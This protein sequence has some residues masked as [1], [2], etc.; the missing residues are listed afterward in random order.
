[1]R[2]NNGEH[3]LTRPEQPSGKAEHGA[4]GL[5]K[6]QESGERRIQSGSRE[7]LK[8]QGK[9]QRRKDEEFSHVMQALISEGVHL[10]LDA[11]KPNSFTVGRPA[12]DARGELMRVGD[13]SILV[14]DPKAKAII[15]RA[16]DEIISRDFEEMDFSALEKSESDSHQEASRVALR[17]ERK[18]L[19][20]DE[21]RFQSLVGAGGSMPDPA[22]RVLE[23]QRAQEAAKLVHG[24]LE[25][26]SSTTD[27]SRETTPS[28]SIARALIREQESVQDELERLLE[29]KGVAVEARRAEVSEKLTALED[30]LKLVESD[31]RERLQTQVRRKREFDSFVSKERTSGMPEERATNLLADYY[32]L[33]AGAA[34]PRLMFTRRL[35][36]EKLDAQELL[37]KTRRSSRFHE[38]LPKQQHRVDVAKEILGAIQETYP[39]I[40]EHGTRG[41]AE[42]REFVQSSKNVPK[43]ILAEAEALYDGRQPKRPFTEF[44]LAERLKAGTEFE[45]IARGEKRGDADV[46]HSRVEKIGAIL[47]MIDP[48]IVQSLSERRIEEKAKTEDKRKKKLTP[49]EI[50]RVSQG[51]DPSQFAL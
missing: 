38:D 44:L 10:T 16:Q 14:H 2:K 37:D 7:A 24:Y 25:E 5:R 50:E 42:L 35:T 17:K 40:M 47:S 19:T 8:E 29:R 45:A 26:F 31:A 3:A 21:T 43:E 11:K 36:K 15:K 18:R 1:M 48:R 28:L 22:S 13:V 32:L 39:G 33:E 34:P 30:R 51:M 20:G 27:A 12:E 49:E 6:K 9:V 4:E 23:V 41:V 46:A